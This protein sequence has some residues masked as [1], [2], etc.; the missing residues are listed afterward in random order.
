M[1]VESSNLQLP[2]DFQDGIP[3]RARMAF[4][5][6]ED[7]TFDTAGQI[8][9]ILAKEG[10]RVK[11]GAI[12]AQLDS[13]SIAKLNHLISK[14]KRDLNKARESLTIAKLTFENTPND[15]ILHAEKI[16]KAK[17]A[18]ESAEIDLNNFQRSY[19]KSLAD[20]SKAEATAQVTLRNARESLGDFERDHEKSLATALK[21]RAD[22]ES[23]LEK[24]N[25]A[26]KNFARDEKQLLDDAMDVASAASL[27]LEVAQDALSDF[28]I[29]YELEVSTAQILVG[30]EEEDL[31]TAEDAVSNFLHNPQDRN[32]K[33]GT[34]WD[35]EALARLRIKV[36]LAQVDLA[37]AKADLVR[38][39]DGPNPLKQ[40]DLESAV[41]LAKS[42]L[43]KAQDEVKDLSDGV[44]DIKFTQR[45]AAVKISENKLEQATIDL[46]EK[47][48]GPDLSDKLKL[49]SGVKVAESVL[50]DATADLS[51]KLTG[52]DSETLELKKT[53][54]DKR[55]QELFELT[56]GP[57]EYEVEVKQTALEL[58]MANLKE[59][60]NELNG[61]I[62]TAPF[63]G[64]INL[65]NGA[66]SDT[67]NKKSYIFQIIDPRVAEVIA[68][69]NAS[70]LKEI[71]IGNRARITIS[72]NNNFDG[73]V[74]H[75]AENPDT[76]RGIVSYALRISIII[77]QDSEI[78]LNMSAVE[79]TVY[80]Q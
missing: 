26:L 40:K 46:S 38:I 80:T 53:I 56:D 71:N 18:L 68:Q 64:I 35:L 74:T 37:Q 54:L 28:I 30:T 15:K 75:I 63:D 31:E 76:D 19:N 16:A 79:A 43:Q 13:I 17:V 9:K 73:F 4:T 1:L 48:K 72:P 47:E 45:K 41:N 69:V 57:D 33:D 44:D 22:S 20:A 23:E 2:L 78:P 29:D 65:V 50:A 58:A 42:K 55:R 10:D 59:S 70:K 21:L 77:P 49:Q 51:R 66:E 7:L 32:V 67:V 11:E 52:P 27:T 8:G 24:A 36:D 25:L 60:L 34:Y 39:Q 3:I 61:T 5:R 12:L 6:S 62:I 14:N